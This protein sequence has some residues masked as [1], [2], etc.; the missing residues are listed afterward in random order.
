MRLLS[1]AIGAALALTLTAP[2]AAQ[3]SP[4]F[5]Y[6]SAGT[7]TDPRPFTLGFSFNLS[8]ATTIDALGYWTGGNFSTHQVAI[9]SSSGTLL[10]SGTV[11]GADPLLGH[12]R[13]DSIAP[14][15]LGAGNYVI[16]GQF[17]NGLIPAELTGITSAPNFTWTGDRQAMGNFVFPTTSFLTYGNQ[18]VALVNFSIAQPA[19]VPEPATW[20]TMLIGFGAI[21][22]SLRRRRRAAAGLLHV[23]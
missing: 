20:A 1:A 9:W 21:G 11:S 19:G 16:G 5:E 14:I 13:Y 22:V 6:T 18:G 2:A 7:L 12:Y 17:F 3:L 23:A 4:A 8:Q 15:T 10:T